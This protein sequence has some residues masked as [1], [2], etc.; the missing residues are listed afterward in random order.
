MTHAPERIA[1]TASGR[2]I[3]LDA[4]DSAAIHLPD[5]ADALANLTCWRGAT[6]PA[7]LTL[8][9]HCVSVANAMFVVD[10]ALAGLYGLLHDAYQMLVAEDAPCRADMSRAVHAR[11]DLDW[12]PPAPARTLLRLAHDR[13]RLTEMKDVCRGRGPEIAE[14]E[15]RGVMRLPTRLHI[16]TPANARD[17]WLSKFES[18]AGLAGLRRQGWERIR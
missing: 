9:Q 12:P 7:A 6:N 18:F 10:G 16:A 17:A 4:P 8:A 13:V 15:A 14:M 3:D 1:V 11:F 5:L 2:R